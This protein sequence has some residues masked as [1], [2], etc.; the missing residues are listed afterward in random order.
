MIL[1]ERLSIC[2]ERGACLIIIYTKTKLK[3]KYLIE[4]Y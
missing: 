1:K 2:E 3:T 4:K